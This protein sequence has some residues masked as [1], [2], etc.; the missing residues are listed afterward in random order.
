MEE[1]AFQRLWWKVR[2]RPRS[3]QL[4]PRPASG[5]HRGPD[6]QFSNAEGTATKK[7]ILRTVAMLHVFTVAQV[8]PRSISVDSA[9]GG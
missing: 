1:N 6:R 9:R 7:A 3:P 8:R 5:S 4:L 2:D